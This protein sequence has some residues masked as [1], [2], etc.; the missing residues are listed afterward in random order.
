MLTFFRTGAAG[1]GTF[2]AM[3][4]IVLSA[5]FC[6]LLADIGTHPAEFF[7]PIAS[8]AHQ[9]GSCIANGGTLHIQL[10]TACHHLYIFFLQAGRSTV[11]TQSGAT[12]AGID[13][14][15]II[16][17]IHKYVFINYRKTYTLAGLLLH[18]RT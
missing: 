10:D 9:L 1:T 11:I 18:H 15:L 13:T 14:L 4:V 6:A 2:L 12:Q 7:R 16:V 5:F 3:F 17:V 8:Q